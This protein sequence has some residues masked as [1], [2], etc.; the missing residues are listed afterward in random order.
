MVKRIVQGY[1]ATEGKGSL[2][3]FLS[4]IIQAVK[5]KCWSSL[6][7]LPIPLSK[8]N[9]SSV[10]WAFY[11]TFKNYIFTNKGTPHSKSFI[12]KMGYDTHFSEICFFHSSGC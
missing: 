2:A 1:R 9:Y 10:W 7:S 6:L 12:R 8:I 5:I 4:K 11:Q 3:P